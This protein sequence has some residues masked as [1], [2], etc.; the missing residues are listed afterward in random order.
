MSSEDE[1]ITKPPE[2]RAP[3]GRAS[4]GNRMSKLLA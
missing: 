1:E 3:T 2:R 4:K